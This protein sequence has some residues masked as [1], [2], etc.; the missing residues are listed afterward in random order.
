MAFTV[1][2]MSDVTRLL[3]EH[4]EWRAEVRRL[5]LTDQLLDL[6]QVVRDLA[7]RMDQLAEHV[8]QLAQR[9]D[10]L[11]QRT[12]QLAQRMDQLAE[13]M[14]QLTARMD[15]LA[16]R[17]DQL[18]ARMDQLATSMDELAVSHQRMY[19]DIGGM[20]GKMLELEYRERCSPYFGRLLRKPRLVAENDLWDRLEGTLSARELDD[21]LLADAYVQGRIRAHPDR[22]EV[23]LVVEVSFVVDGFDVERAARR[24]ALLR[25]AGLSAVAVAAGERVTQSARDAAQESGVGLLERLEPIYWEDALRHAAA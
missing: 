21:A 11:A 23:I 9:M 16:A 4:P 19:D 22:D 5:V 8:D 6:P 1:R 3:V 17:M 2:D 13:R 25:R 15:Q 18:T 12:D 10:Q 7:E 24:A 20:K 14:D